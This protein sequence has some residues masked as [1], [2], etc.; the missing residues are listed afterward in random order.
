MAIADDISV[1]A[2]GD[3]RYTGSSTNYTV[4][5]FHRFLQDLADDALASGDDLLDI[6]D[7]TPSERSTDNIITLNSPY[8]ID[9]TLAQHLYDGS[10]TQADGDTVY[11]GL[12]VVGSVETGTELQIVQDDKII[13]NY[14]TTGI[15]ADAGANIL[16]RLMVKTRQFGA[17]IDGKRLRVQARELG[18]TYSEFLLTAGLGNSTAAI[19]TSADLNNQTAEGTISGWSSIV[20]TEG[21]QLLDVTG[22][23]V[24]EEYYSQWDLG[25][26]TINDLYERT[27]WIQRRGTAESI[28]SMNGEKFRGIS[29]SLAYD[30]EASGPFTEDEDIV[31]GTSFNYDGETGDTQVDVSAAISDD[32]GV[33]T[34]ETTAANDATTLDITLLPA[35]PAV[36]DAFYVGKNYPFSEVD[37]DIG[38]QGVGTWTITWEYY[39]G[40]WV[41]L[42][43]VTDGTSGFTAAAGVQ[44][45]SFDQPID[46]QTN[47]VN[48]QGPFYYIRAR[49]SAYTSVTTAPVGDEVNIQP[50]WAIG[51]YVKF[52]TSGAVGKL[53][54]VTDSGATGSMIVAIESGSGTVVDNDPISQA[55][56]GPMAAAIQG[57]PSDTAAAGGMG[58]LIAL[59]DNGVTGNLYLQLLSGSAPADNLPMRGL[60]SGATADVNGSPTARTISPEFIGTSTGSAIIGAYGIG[61][62]TNDLT[63]SDQLFDLSNTLRVPPNNVTFTVAGLI[64]GEDRVL[65]GPEN[66]SGGLDLDQLSLNTTLSSSTETQVVVTASIPSDTPSSGSIRV[67]T[68]GGIYK[69][70]HYS[71]FTGSTFTMDSGH[72]DYATFRDFSSDNATASNNVFISYID[73]LAAAAS[74]NFTVVFNAP[75]T[76]FIRVRDGGASPIKTFETTGTLGSAGGSSTAIRTSD[77]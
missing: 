62:D 74:E 26:Q 29:H 32:G 68:D 44:T 51:E 31:W 9:D 11:S 59:D 13:H 6:T 56:G 55:A 69:L 4:I 46:W 3:I 10:V 22:D 65:V 66:G 39:N 36:N 1:A 18:D 71:S 15:N 38:T 43:N 52:A 5:E 61:V 37:F 12:V 49:V 67:Q 70:V 47:S 30:N 60:S 76:L 24:N 14:W 42:E 19:F 48:S 33:F 8:N 50:K 64:S 53:L 40:G 17:D 35:T 25:S 34:D 2:N 23:A 58:R 7:E 27:K 28:H 54:Q 72:A 16:L 73:K 57:T 45:V 20:N 77:A 75:R 21:F 41:P 63:A